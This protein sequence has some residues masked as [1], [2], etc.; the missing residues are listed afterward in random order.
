MSY[1]D[2]FVI[3]FSGLKP[4]KHDYSFDIDD[5]F[6]AH[7]E[8]SEIKSGRL[9]VDLV[10]EKK[11]NLLELDFTIHGTVHV[12]CDRCLDHFDQPVNGSERLFIKFGVTAYEE[13]DEVV[14]IPSTEHRINV[15]HF[16]YEYI[17]LLLPYK[18]IH[19]NDEE[20]LSQCN[21]EVVSRLNEHIEPGMGD[22]R[23]DTLK[24]LL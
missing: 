16:I 1:F 3:P 5:A 22:P 15:S 21:P 23:W 7:F 11:E 12:M 9:T 2:H 17:H 4:G 14:V 10:L 6:F 13:S 18:C 20:G 8:Y 24:K 19:P